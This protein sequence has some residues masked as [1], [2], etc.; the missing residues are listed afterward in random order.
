MGASDINATGKHGRGNVVCKS[1]PPYVRQSLLHKSE[2]HYVAYGHLSNASH[3]ERAGRRVCE[4]VFK[5][6]TLDNEMP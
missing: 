5:C 4:L 1:E 2:L 6:E 3:R